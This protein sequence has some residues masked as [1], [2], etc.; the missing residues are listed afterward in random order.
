[1]KKDKKT[2]NKQ[3]NRKKEKFDFKSKGKNDP[4]QKK[5]WPDDGIQHLQ[6]FYCI[7]SAT[8]PAIVC[9]SSC[10]LPGKIISKGKFIFVHF[11]LKKFPLLLCHQKKI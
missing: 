6:Q 7:S 11:I 2:I 3:E 8:Q 1:M 4:Q 10:S 5:R 9:A